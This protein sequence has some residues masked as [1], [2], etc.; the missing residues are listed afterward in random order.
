MFLPCMLERERV[1]K[2][3]ASQFAVDCTGYNNL[4]VHAEGLDVKARIRDGRRQEHEGG[5]RDGSEQGEEDRDGE[6]EGRL[7]T[8][9][10]REHPGQ[11]VDWEQMQVSVVEYKRGRRVSGALAVGVRVERELAKE[12]V[13]SPCLGTVFL[14]MID[15]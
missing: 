11:R 6:G 2:Q 10:G 4:N 5:E 13:A 15:K 3:R 8:L 1:A 7:E 12:L 9:V 14:E